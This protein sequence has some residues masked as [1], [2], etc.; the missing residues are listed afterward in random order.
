MT[1]YRFILLLCALLAWSVQAQAGCS[2]PIVVPVSPIGLSV[3]VKNDKVSGV[4]PEFMEE[5]A[6]LAGCE[7]RMTPVPRARLE[8]MFEQGTADIL[9]AATHA[10][11]RDQF[12][13]FIPLV[14]TRAMLVSLESARSPIHSIEELLAFPALKV[15]LVRGFDYG[16]AYLGMIEKLRLQGRVSFEKD[17]LEV[18]RLLKAHIVDVTIMPASALYGAAVGDPR[19]SDIANRLR[20][21][22]LD[23]LPWAPAGVYLSLRSLNDADRKTLEAALR[24]ASRG[25]RLFQ[26]YRR[27]YPA[28]LV[29]LG[30]RAL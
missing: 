12:G 8:A 23:D 16:P 5:V 22:P 11:H 21:E 24:E 30:T 10:E 6:A 13:Q 28:H 20:A 29:A 4:F 17:P 18:A 2:R 3:V 1:A 9:V 26:A 14:Q 19:V 25:Q 15:A 7:L 27:Y